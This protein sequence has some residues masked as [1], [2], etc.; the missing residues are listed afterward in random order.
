M[1][2]S[3]IR[4][5]EYQFDVIIGNPP[6][7]LTDASNSA[8]ASPIYQKFIEQA[9]AL[10]PRYLTMVTPSR[11]FVG[12]KGLDEFRGKMLSDQRLRVMVDFIVDKDAFPKINVN[13]GVNFFLWDRDHKGE[14]EITTVERGGMTEP[15]VSR[16]L[17]EFDVFIRRNQSVSIL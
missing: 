16:S 3:D 9:I 11:W 14:C 12:G 1:G 15:S 10:E 7:Q 8:S 13:G 6:Y 2:V 5:K 4:E 17:N